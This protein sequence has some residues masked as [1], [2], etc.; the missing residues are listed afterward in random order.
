MNHPI[1]FLDQ[2]NK[3][4]LVPASFSHFLELLLGKHNLKSVVVINNRFNLSLVIKLMKLF[5]LH[6][7]CKK[8]VEQS[9]NENFRV[10]ENTL[11]NKSGNLESITK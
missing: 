4:K 8:V 2:D 11:S 10:I 3:M 5:H 7:S 6:Y 9:K 1:K